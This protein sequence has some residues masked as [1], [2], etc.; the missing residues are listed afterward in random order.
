MFFMCGRPLLTLTSV[1]FN[2]LCKL[3]I[4]SCA[5]MKYYHAG[6]RRGSTDQDTALLK[7]LGSSQ[8]WTLL[9]GTVEE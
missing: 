2:V 4:A 3:A 7:T 5:M 1:T 9:R 8:R 6:L